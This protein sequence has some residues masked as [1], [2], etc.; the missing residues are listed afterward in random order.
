MKFARIFS[1]SAAALFAVISA[2]RAG[3]VQMLDGTFHEG[4]VTLDRGIS[5]RGATNVKVAVAQVLFAR[6][7]D[8]APP[9]QV[10]PGLVLTNG[11][12]I[13]G[14]FSPLL[15]NPVTIAAKNLRLPSADVALGVYQPF[16]ETL[17]RD[18]PPGKL[19]ALLP[20]GDFFEGTIKSADARGARVVNSIFGPKVFPAASKHAQA[21]VLR[22]STPQPAAFEV[23]TKDGSHYLA[24]DVVSEDIISVVLRH[25]HYDGLR[26]PTGEVVE[27]R[28]AP[29]RLLDL[30]AIKPVDSAAGSNAENADGSRLRL[31][32]QVVEGCSVS[33]GS[34][35]KWR[36][37][38]RGGVFYGRVAA[39]PETAAGTPLVYVAE[40][41]GRVLFR[42]SAIPAGSPPQVVRFAVPAAETLTLRVEGTAGRGIWADPIIVL[43]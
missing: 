42:S 3:T 36:R 2:A 14:A 40:A 19:G 18:L 29:N 15:E 5:I 34:A 32:T 7:T 37:T 21:I 1:L 8:E 11:T 16:S 33:A 10:V 13:A 28:A 22:G 20:G 41:D 9:A 35:V 27:I 4:T 24:L 6:F 31:G 17:L 39:G 25:P 30:S 23:I 38:V 12:R 43:R 26:I